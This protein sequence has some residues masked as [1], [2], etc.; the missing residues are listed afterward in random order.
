MQNAAFPPLFPAAAVPLTAA[1]G[2]TAY[3]AHLTMP[4]QSRSRSIALALA[5][6]AGAVG[7]GGGGAGA[8]SGACRQDG[9]AEI[10]TGTT[11]FESVTAGQELTIVAGP[12][13]GHHFILNARQKGLEPGD[14][15]KP[16][17]AGNPTTRFAT[18]LG[19]RQVDIM[20]PPYR[21]GYEDTGDG[22]LTMASGH[23][24]PFQEDALADV[25][26][27]TVRIE[28]EISDVNGLCA[29]ADTTVTAVPGPEPDGGSPD[30]GP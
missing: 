9:E 21:L 23:I 17:L 2:G 18:Y 26:G 8:D 4:K 16:G 13:G 14:P 12:Q 10:G 5:G 1:S 20:Q 29:R 22:Y 28:V 3:T 24:I 6:L 25:D 19:D 27:Q 15:T 30:A 7:C 11:A